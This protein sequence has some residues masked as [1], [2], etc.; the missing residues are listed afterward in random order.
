MVY[1]SRMAVWGDESDAI[2]YRPHTFVYYTNLFDAV[3]RSDRIGIL[4]LAFT[5]SPR[6][7]Y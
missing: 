4:L 6:H 3:P 7:A 1:D 5:L 2:H